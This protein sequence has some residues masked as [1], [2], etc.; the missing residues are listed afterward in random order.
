[1]NDPYETLGVA[2]TASR[3]EIKRAYRKGAKKAHPDR[4]GGS[5]A[6]MSELNR[7]YALLEDPAKRARYDAGDDPDREPQSIEAQAEEML[8]SAM[9]AVFSVHKDSENLAESLRKT[10]LIAQNS[11]KQEVAKAERAAKKASKVLRC[12]KKGERFRPMFE[13]KVA[14]AKRTE[15]A[16]RRNLE[17]LSLALKL[18]AE[19]GW[20]DPEAPA[21]PGRFFYTNARS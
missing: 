11:M 21:A 4:A 17:A 9:D 13:K 15:A 8:L 1:M 12:L 2:R 6:K 7:A 18:A 16:V 14:E 19:V 5:N 10:L 20:E 3:D